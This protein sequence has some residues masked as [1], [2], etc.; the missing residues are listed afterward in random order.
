[1]YKQ[2]R[3]GLL[4]CLVL[5]DGGD[6]RGVGEFPNVPNIIL[7][8]PG[9]L[10]PALGVGVGLEGG[11][12]LAIAPAVTPT[13]E[14]RE[15]GLALCVFVCA[16]VC[17]FPSLC[18]FSAQCGTCLKFETDEARPR[19]LPYSEVSLM[20]LLIRATRTRSGGSICACVCACVCARVRV[21]VC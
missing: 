7:E 2:Q 10:R 19:C 14:H 21:C 5:G 17:V 16:S 11:L 4:V 6:L 3:P 15:T 1:M 18:V 8:R 12:A 13:E 20:H 9:R